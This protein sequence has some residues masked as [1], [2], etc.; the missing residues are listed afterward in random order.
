VIHFAT[1]KELRQNAGEIMQKI[2]KG[3]RYIVTYRGK[4][5]ALLL[6]FPTGP[7]EEM[8]PRAYEEAWR[9]IEATLHETEAKYPR[10]DDAIRESRRRI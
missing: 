10:W 7:V 6:P 4:P 3:E 8:V 2:K 5:V 1:S 9:D